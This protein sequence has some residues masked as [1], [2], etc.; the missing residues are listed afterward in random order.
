MIFLLFLEV[1]SLYGKDDPKE[2][3][4]ILDN[5]I[6]DEPE[7]LFHRTTQVEAPLFM[8]ITLQQ[9]IAFTG[10]EKHAWT[11]YGDTLKGILES[12]LPGHR[13]EVT[14]HPNGLLWAQVDG[15][16]PDSC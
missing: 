11:K 10:A 2:F 16:A 8:T 7:R 12:Y 4:E 14:M 15:V 1:S 5:L 3:E 13:Q 9:Y 6:A